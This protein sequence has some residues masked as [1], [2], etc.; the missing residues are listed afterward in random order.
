MTKVARQVRSAQWPKLDVTSAPRVSARERDELAHL[1]AA[2]RSIAETAYAVRVQSRNA[3]RV[4]RV[5]EDMRRMLA[6]YYDV[7]LDSART[8]A[9]ALITRHVETYAVVSKTRPDH[10]A[11]AR[12]ILW[13]VGLL[14]PELRAPIARIEPGLTTALE[15]RA[16]VPSRM[17]WA[18]LS[19][20]WSAIEPSS[21]AEAWRQAHAKTRRA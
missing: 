3:K 10:A 5:S 16:A 17:P 9:R 13:R 4:Q 21:L 1:V 18:E 19:L 6:A 2:V 20:A 15:R 8:G 14:W 7:S 12:L 11:Y